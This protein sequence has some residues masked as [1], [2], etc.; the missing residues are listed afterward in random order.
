MTVKR[1]DN[2]GFSYSFVSDSMDYNS[3][4]CAH[5]VSNFTEGNCTQQIIGDKMNCYCEY[6]SDFVLLQRYIEPDLRRILF[7]TTDNMYLTII[8]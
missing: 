3:T 1:I 8:G 2:Y 4:R 5:I 6:L 7:V